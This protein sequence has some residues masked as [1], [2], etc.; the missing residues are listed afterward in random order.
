MKYSLMGRFLQAVSYL[1]ATNLV[2]ITFGTFYA[3]TLFPKM[4]IKLSTNR[5]GY[6]PIGTEWTCNIP[7]KES[8]FLL[9]KQTNPALL[10]K[11]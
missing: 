4:H 8:I 3:V 10:H 9:K 2:I 6:T 7:A 5:L 1:T 11:D